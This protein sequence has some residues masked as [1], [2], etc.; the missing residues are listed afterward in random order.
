MQKPIPRSAVLSWAMY[1][2]ANTIFS[3]NIVSFYFSVWV[4]N[5]MGGTDADYS[6]ANAFSMGLMFLSAPVLG[7]LSDQISRRMPF[8]IFTTVTCVV[9]TALLGMGGL[10]LSIVFFII[11]NYMFQAGLIFYDSLLPVVSTEENRGRVGG[12]GIGLGYVG[13]FIGMGSGLL[14]LNKIG[15]VGVFRMTALLFFVF[16]LPC[17]IFVH[18]PVSDRARQIDLGAMVRGAFQQVF[19]TIRH[20]REFPGLLRFLVG[21]LFYTD[22]VNTIIVFMGIYVTN[23]VGFTESEA[24]VLMLVA[25]A[26]AVVGGFIWGVVVDRFQPARSLLWVLISWKVAILGAFLIAVL[27]LPKALFWG[28]ACLAGISLGGTWAA[29]RPL[30]LKLAPKE[31]LGE[32]YGLYS[33]VGRFASVVGPLLWGLIVNTLGWGRP[34]AVFSLLLLLIV[35]YIILLPLKE[36]A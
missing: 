23:E 5:K 11:A 19:K 12:L 27:G 18:E 13:S 26:A 31:F 34:A 30:M 16:A 24:Q 4:V 7:A 28:V 32:F 8:L 14:L 22:P 36:K 35:A 1:D 33:M 15:Y 17:F 9:F 21:R 10:F 2:L 6:F 20:A 29:D 3:M 25:I